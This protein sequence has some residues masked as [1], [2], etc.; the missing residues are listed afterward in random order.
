MC[1]RKPNY[2]FER[3]Q[4]N[5]AKEIKAQQKAQKKLEKAAGEEGGVPG[6]EPAA[7]GEG[8]A[9]SRD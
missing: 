9:P 5:K 8:R 6:G 2:D 4:R 1:M 3:S 7:E